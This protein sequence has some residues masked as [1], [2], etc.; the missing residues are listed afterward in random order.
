MKKTCS[1]CN[2]SFDTNR[3]DIRFCDGDCRVII[4]RV[5]D[6]HAKI[7]GTDKLVAF[8]EATS[9]KD[10]KAA[11]IWIPNWK[12]NGN[13]MRGAES[14]MLDIMEKM[15]GSYIYQGLRIKL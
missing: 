2:K 3:E 9:V 15:K 6:N 4:K 5:R 1:R 12:L 14:T 8:L 7:N 11:G 10:L 13:T